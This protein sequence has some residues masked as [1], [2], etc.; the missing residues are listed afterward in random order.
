M[1]LRDMLGKL[2]GVLE[3]IFSDLLRDLL[4]W[5]EMGSVVLHCSV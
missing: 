4:I 2:G 3:G 1:M 5:V